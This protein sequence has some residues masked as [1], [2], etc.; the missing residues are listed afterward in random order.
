MNKN[1][2][3]RRRRAAA[4]GKKKTTLQ[5]KYKKPKHLA[6]KT[7]PQEDALCIP[8]RELVENVAPRGEL[9]KGG[10]LCP[11]SMIYL[12]GKSKYGLLGEK[13]IGAGT[14]SRGECSDN[15]GR[16]GTRILSCRVCWK[17]RR[18]FPR[19]SEHVVGAV[20]DVVPSVPSTRCCSIVGSIGSSPLLS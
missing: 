3:R 2:G 7:N 4:V 15:Y 19:Y 12:E 14:H 10:C 16:L 9:K 6:T 8:R 20:V 18:R 11:R 17:K 13:V 1:P 5:C